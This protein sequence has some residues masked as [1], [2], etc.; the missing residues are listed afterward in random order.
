VKKYYP[1]IFIVFGVMGIVFSYEW[2]FRGYDYFDLSKSLVNHP[3]LITWL[4]LM[5]IKTTSY[6]IL[7]PFLL[8]E[9]YSSK[10]IIFRKR[11]YLISTV[12]LITLLELLMS[13]YG[14]SLF[15]YLRSENFGGEL[16]S[17]VK[18]QDIISNMWGIVSGL[19]FALIFQYTFKLNDMMEDF[20]TK[21]RHAHSSSEKTTVIKQSI[22]NISNLKKDADSYFYLLG[23]I[24]ALSELS[25]AALREAAIEGHSAASF[26]IEVVYYHGLFQ[27]L[28]I[29]II[30]I[31]FSFY[32]KMKAQTILNYIEGDEYY[33]QLQPITD[34]KLSIGAFKKII[35]IISPLIAAAIPALLDNIFK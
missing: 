34:F 29:A 10:E 22:K 3:K 30:Y 35:P 14:S 19:L 1:F 9:L 4:V 23:F 26:P 24:I 15:G 17:F 33:K 8:S 25:F 2:M 6:F 5:V 21:L 11:G 16:K 12:I 18:G 28:L 20:K 32:F 27:S 31:P 7:L 13:R